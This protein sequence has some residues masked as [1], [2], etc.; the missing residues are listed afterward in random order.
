MMG[1]WS[2][3]LAGRTERTEMTNRC[4]MVMMTIVRISYGEKIKDMKLKPVSYT[5]VHGT[6]GF[7]VGKR[8]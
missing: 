2:G 4:Q 8:Y 1:F 6:S 3:L 7:R 5:V